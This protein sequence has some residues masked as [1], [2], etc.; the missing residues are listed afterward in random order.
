MVSEFLK[1]KLLNIYHRLYGRYGPQHWWPGD[2][3]FEVIMGAILTQSASWANVE[4]AL[5]NLKARGLL[6]PA[7]LRAIAQEELA[8]LIRPSVYFNVK[9][10]KVKAFVQHLGEQYDDDLE[11]LLGKDAQPLRQELLS[12]FGIGE[13]TADDILLYAANKPIFV[14]DAYTRRILDRLGLAPAQN[15]Y[16]A[17]QLLLMEGLP[18]DVRLFNEYHALLDRHGVET[19][20]K[21][22]PLCGE[23]CLLDMCPAGARLSLQG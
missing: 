18:H 7:A 6:D 17:Y 9:A 1:D 11:A 4:A 10:R 2:G 8:H 16:S 5:A 20:R 3:A 14:I 21:R 23:C 19:C 13:E 22:E 15:G 12:I